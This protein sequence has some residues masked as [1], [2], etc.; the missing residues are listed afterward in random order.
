MELG[1][2][3]MYLEGSVKSAQDRNLPVDRPVKSVYKS[4][5]GRALAW[6]LAS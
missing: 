5:P 2:S 1:L 6:S 3:E 4:T